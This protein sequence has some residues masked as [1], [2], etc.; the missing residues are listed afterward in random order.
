MALNKVCKELG[1]RFGWCEEDVKAVLLEEGV[2]NPSD[3][4]LKEAETE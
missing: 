3:V 4:Q 1:L 2:T